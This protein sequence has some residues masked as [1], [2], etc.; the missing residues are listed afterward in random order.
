MRSIAATVSRK[1]WRRTKSAF[2][3]I[4]AGR[5]LAIA[6]LHPAQGQ[7]A[8]FQRLRLPEMGFDCFR[9]LS[10]LIQDLFGTLLPD[11]RDPG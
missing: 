11:I 3:G 5:Q 10:A 4:E 8:R 9:E 6:V 7:R 1:F 2:L